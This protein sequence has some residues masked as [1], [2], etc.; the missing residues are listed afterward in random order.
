[1]ENLRDYNIPHE[2]KQLVA[3]ASRTELEVILVS[4]DA[5]CLIAGT[6]RNFE[7]RQVG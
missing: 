7:G 4:D 2:R 1:M 5:R 6:G 3:V